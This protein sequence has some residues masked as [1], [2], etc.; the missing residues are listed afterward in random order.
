MVGRRLKPGVDTAG[1]EPCG[2][3]PATLGRAVRGGESRRWGAWHK[4]T[5]H[6]SLAAQF[7]AK[8]WRIVVITIV[9][10]SFFFGTEGTYICLDIRIL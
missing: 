4:R 3:P 9:A 8:R 7:V 6:A 2:G 5:W 1:N 10:S